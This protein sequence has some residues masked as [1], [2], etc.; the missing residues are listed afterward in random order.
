MEK[1]S[2]WSRANPNMLVTRIH[3]LLLKGLVSGGAAPVITQ[4]E[5]APARIMD[6]LVI[7]STCILNAC[8]PIY[9]GTNVLNRVDLNCQ[10]H[11]CAALSLSHSL[12][13]SLSRSL[14]LSLTHSL[15]PLSVTI[16][17]T[18][19]LTHIYRIEDLQIDP[20]YSTLVRHTVC[21]EPMLSAASIALRDRFL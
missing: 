20:R 3:V 7:S 18:L 5:S 8:S 4:P 21:T 16:T 12:A 6:E 10:S 19:T 14:T 9:S 1:L 17:S 11:T 2:C 13:R 15:S